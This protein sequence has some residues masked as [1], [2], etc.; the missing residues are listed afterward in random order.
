MI[1]LFTAGD[2]KVLRILSGTDADAAVDR[3]AAEVS[4]NVLRRCLQG[5]GRLVAADRNFCST[6]CRH[7]YNLY[8]WGE[9]R[10]SESLT[11]ALKASLHLAQYNPD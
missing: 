9:G 2:G 4:K 7:R 3:L 5:C 11:L 1:T 8:T 6:H 10:G